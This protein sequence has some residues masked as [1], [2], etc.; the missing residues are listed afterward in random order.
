MT[1]EQIEMNEKDFITELTTWCHRDGITDLIKWLQNETDFFTSPASTKYHL[2]EAGG[3]CE[4]SLNVFTQMENIFDTDEDEME[5]IAIVGLLHDLC[6]VNFYA[7]EYRNKKNEKTGIW[8]K[9]PV[10]TV[11]DQFPYGHGEKS[12]YLISKFIKLTD[13]EA[14]AIRWHMGGFD[15]AVKGG[16]FGCTKAFEK[17]PLAVKLHCADMLATYIDEVK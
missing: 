12:V 7:I 5:S 2:C 3:L 16:D 9:Y 11:E 4:H 10:Y 14:M 6:K 13:E 1:N 15:N 17:Y 8:E